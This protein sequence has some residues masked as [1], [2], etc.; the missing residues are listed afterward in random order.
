MTTPEIS[1]PLIVVGVDGSP[2]S[3]KAVAWG[4]EQ[5][6]NTGGTLELLIAWA[7]P[8]SYGLPL[9]V[10]GLDPEA[11]AREIVEKAA[12]D[13]DLPAERVIINVVHGAAPSILVERSSHAD[14]LVVGSRGHGGFAELLLGSVSAQAVHHASCPVVVIR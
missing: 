10:A 11:Q 13:V 2:Q 12:A 9:V 8:V 4:I 6:K 3:Q 7:R 5:A 14:L 1:R